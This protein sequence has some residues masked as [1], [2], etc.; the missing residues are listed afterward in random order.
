MTRRS[1]MK[2]TMVLQQRWVRWGLIFGF[3][4]LLGVFFGIQLY[5]INALEY[6]HPISWRQAMFWALS[7]WYIWAMLSPLGLWLA[8]PFHLSRERWAQELRAHFPARV[9]VARCH[10]PLRGAGTQGFGCESH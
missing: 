8:R 10:P 9:M 1:E 2:E 6:R 5:L 4:T 3:W 7:G